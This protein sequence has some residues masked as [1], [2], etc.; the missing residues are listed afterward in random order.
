MEVVR[1]SLLGASQ[2]HTEHGE[3]WNVGLWT[4]HG[5][6]VGLGPRPLEQTFM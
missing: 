2:A 5:D 1:D 6:P 4:R 3:Q